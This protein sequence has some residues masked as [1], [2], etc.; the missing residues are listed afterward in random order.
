MNANRCVAILLYIEL[1]ALSE[2][3]CFVSC[4]YLKRNFTGA[5]PTI[6]FDWCDIFETSRKMKSFREAEQ[7]LK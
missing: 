3:I 7:S 6:A 1:T 5:W 2:V 4:I